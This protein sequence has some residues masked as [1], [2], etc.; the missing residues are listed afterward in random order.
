MRMHIDLDP[1]LVKRIDETAGER[2]RSRFVREAILLELDRRSRS[3]SIRKAF[4]SIM[5]E[6]HVWDADPV[7][8]VHSQ[9]RADSER[10]G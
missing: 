2:G 8:W 5:R 10:T 4:G 9:R 6:G 7:D 3:D 1:E